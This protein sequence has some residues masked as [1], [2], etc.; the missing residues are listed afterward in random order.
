[1]NKKRLGK[2]R[3]VAETEYKADYKE[4][5]I[6]KQKRKIARRLALAVNVFSKLI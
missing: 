3:R 1:V 2:E 6:D 5:D 4:R